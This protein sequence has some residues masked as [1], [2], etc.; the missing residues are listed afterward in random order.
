MPSTNQTDLAGRECK[1]AGG[2]DYAACQTCG[3]EYDWRK[4]ERPACPKPK[5]TSDQRLRWRKCAATTFI[6]PVA[7]ALIDDLETAL[8]KI[9]ALEGENASLEAAGIEALERAAEAE[10][11]VTALEGA[12]RPFTDPAID[13]DGDLPENMRLFDDTPNVTVAHV[14]HARAL[15][16]PDPAEQPEAG[17]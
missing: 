13:D 14:R 12:L 4:Q 1:W 8:A 5:T 9:E 10:A 16:N 2:N 7:Y 17:R 11:R 15:L 3:Q 6:A